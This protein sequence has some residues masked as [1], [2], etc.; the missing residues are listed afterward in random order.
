MASM[1]GI[2]TSGSR[3][4]RSNGSKNGQPTLGSLSLAHSVRMRA[5]VRRLRVLVDGCERACGVIEDQ[6][7]HFFGEA[8]LG[9]SFEPLH[10]LAPIR[11]VR[12]TEPVERFG[13]CGEGRLLGVCGD[14]AIK[15]RVVA[16]VPAPSGSAPR[17]LQIQR[18]ASRRNQY[19]S[20]PPIHTL[21]KS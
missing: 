12:N 10:A 8:A 3:G 16:A 6:T 9:P 5:S 18:V 14:P 2:S 1:E 7:T 11:R 19:W 15:G 13:N 4:L 17:E 20:H 21:R